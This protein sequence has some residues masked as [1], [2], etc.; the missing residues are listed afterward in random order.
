[1]GSWLFC[2]FEAAG[3]LFAYLL[4]RGSVK[5]NPDSASRTQNLAS[6]LA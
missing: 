1:M 3:Q 6:E 2:F 5:G 4:A